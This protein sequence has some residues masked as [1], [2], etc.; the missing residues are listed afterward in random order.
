MDKAEAARLI[1]T[2]FHYKPGWTLSAVSVPLDREAIYVAIDADVRNSDVKYAPDY[3]QRA[4]PGFSKFV[5][6]SHI[7][8]E[9]ELARLILEE[10]VLVQEAH[11]SLEFFTWDDTG[12]QNKPF[13]PHTAEGLNNYRATQHLAVQEPE[14]AFAS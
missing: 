8:N 12:Y 14:K 4:Y 6:V 5:N 7:Q 13:H 3:A 1:N 10:F 9:L 11:E 2:K